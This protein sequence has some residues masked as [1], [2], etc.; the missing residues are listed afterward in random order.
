M[1][2]FATEFGVRVDNILR[3]NHIDTLAQ[4][5]RLDREKILSFKSAGGKAVS[6]ICGIQKEVRA[7]EQRGDWIDYQDEKETREKLLAIIVDWENTE[8]CLFSTLIRYFE[9]KFDGTFGDWTEV[10]EE[11]RE[12]YSLAF[13]GDRK[14]T[15]YGSA[16]DCVL[17][18]IS[19]AS[20][21]ACLNNVARTFN[22]DARMLD[23][24]L[25]DYDIKGKKIHSKEL[26]SACIEMRKE[27]DKE[28]DD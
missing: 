23:L 11:G 2:R 10:A 15:E 26:I 3:N 13:N 1:K 28:I 6:E 18:T 9:N 20:Y 8:E 22:I 17:G 24:I 19:A 14:E 7:A 27:L 12:I 5:M 21:N 4:F 25:E 16:I